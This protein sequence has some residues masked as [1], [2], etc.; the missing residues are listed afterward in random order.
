M[1]R[2]ESLPADLQG[3]LPSFKRYKIA[4]SPNAM[5]YA[6]FFA[7]SPAFRKM[8]ADV[9]ELYICDMRRKFTSESRIKQNSDFESLF[10]NKEELNAFYKCMND[11]SQTCGAE[12][13]SLLEER[14]KVNIIISVKGA[15]LFSNHACDALPHAKTILLLKFSANHYEPL[16][17]LTGKH[18]YET[19]FMTTDSRMTSILQKLAEDTDSLIKNQ[20]GGESIERDYIDNDIT[21]DEVIN[22]EDDCNDND[23]QDNGH[24]ELRVVQVSGGSEPLDS[25]SSP[26]PS[27]SEGDIYSTTPLSLD[28]ALTPSYEDFDKFIIPSSDIEIVKKLKERIRVINKAALQFTRYSKD[29]VTR[30]LYNLLHS[31]H[32]SSASVNELETFR[33]LYM[34]INGTDTP[35]IPFGIDLP[36][37]I[38][39]SVKNGDLRQ[40]FITP[41]VHIVQND[42]NVQAAILSLAT[43]TNSYLQKR[44]DIH[45]ILRPYNDATDE[46][47]SEYAKYLVKKTVEAADEDGTSLKLLGQQ[48]I[49][50]N[51]TRILYN[52][53]YVRIREINVGHKSH[54]A[55]HG[56][57]DIERYVTAAQ[58]LKIGSSALLYFNETHV[59]KDGT[60][61]NKATG[62]VSA[63]NVGMLKIA[64]NDNLQIRKWSDPIT[65]N[66]ITIQL[67]PGSP[68]FVYPINTSNTS[69][70]HKS[71]LDPNNNYHVTI[72]VLSDSH[73]GLSKTLLW[74]I[75]TLNES[76]YVFRKRLEH[77]ANLRDAASALPFDFDE[78]S[79]IHSGALKEHIQ[80][81][82]QEMTNVSHHQ[83]QAV[84]AAAIATT[85]RLYTPRRKSRIPI[86]L[87]FSDL[88]SIKTAYPEL[89]WVTQ[90]HLRDAKFEMDYAL[91]VKYLRDHGHMHTL[92]TYYNWVK[93]RVLDIDTIN[94]KRT[95]LARI[96][97]DYQPE[98]NPFILPLESLNVVKNYASNEDMNSDYG[99][100]LSDWNGAY[101]VCKNNAYIRIIDEWVHV[102]QIVQMP[103][104]ANANGVD[105]LAIHM[106]YLAPTIIGHPTTPDQQEYLKALNDHNVAK[107]QLNALDSC[108]GT[109]SIHTLE[110]HITDLKYAL[111]TPYP[112]VYKSPEPSFIDKYYYDEDEEDIREYVIDAAELFSY[113][114]IQPDKVEP[115][116]FDTASPYV[117]ALAAWYN[118]QLSDADYERARINIET[119]TT[120]VNRNLISRNKPPMNPEAYAG[121]VQ[122]YGQALL[123]IFMQISRIYPTIHNVTADS[124]NTEDLIQFIVNNAPKASVDDPVAKKKIDGA[125]QVLRAYNAIISNRPL[126]AKRVTASMAAGKLS[127][128]PHVATWQGFRPPIIGADEVVVGSKTNVRGYITALYKETTQNS[129]PLFAM[130]NKIPLTRNTCCL[131]PLTHAYS[132][133]DPMTH[134]TDAQAIIK[135]KSSNIFVNCAIPTQNKRAQY[136]EINE[137]SKKHAHTIEKDT[138]SVVEEGLDTMAKSPLFPML[139]ADYDVFAISDETTQLYNALFTN[140]DAPF[141]D[142][143]IIASA[144]AIKTNILQ[145]ENHAVIIEGTFKFIRNDMGR[146]MGSMAY[147]LRIPP[148]GED[149][150][151]N[152]FVI[153]ASIYKRT[154]TDIISTAIMCANT[155]CASH[156]KSHQEKSVALS[157]VALRTLLLLSA[158]VNDIQTENSLD[159]LRASTDVRH[160]RMLMNYLLH[161]WITCVNKSNE[162]NNPDEYKARVSIHREKSK[163]AAIDEMNTMTNDEIRLHR[164]LKQRGIKMPENAAP[165][166][167]APLG[168][169]PPADTGADDWQ[170]YEGENED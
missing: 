7:Q 29:G 57:F 24:D 102:G 52:G 65:N 33:A 147:S 106:M 152:L 80:S 19:T 144:T 96:V 76:I 129:P 5:F 78:I 165:V 38:I 77:I 6:F 11:P 3:L 15:T 169:A 44:A 21:N 67:T 136:P 88:D 42:T 71:L 94:A 141:I 87:I 46:D 48:V 140:T 4:V 9:Q 113:A 1:S 105:F 73:G 103:L 26:S 32:V 131:K 70:F 164:E 93:D 130:V 111:D 64:L 112:P 132:Y 68:A 74:I 107:K 138:T 23:N 41:V 128:T 79:A 134:S 118:V 104:N 158:T 83:Q 126:I 143:S 28:E 56:T 98:S 17:I 10:D 13:W 149:Y 59:D 160:A 151:T 30:E 18:T 137:L 166:S 45:D 127:E 114:E 154:I 34:P 81:V 39:A 121:F 14:F 125:E 95:T 75:P 54:N 72:N 145:S 35:R 97:G 2:L 50:A 31:S 92:Q 60:I 150:I 55:I 148:G 146:I 110:N 49:P 123:V 139:V 156:I 25:Q 117:F 115:T 58:G 51:P 20:V 63:N 69:I 27:S 135:S 124:L 22:E 62:I 142:V 161:I 66:I 36:E 53:D 120:S 122:T 116:T 47:A 86:P 43:S 90:P 100:I 8:S 99:R 109:D 170:N 82:A 40:P 159:S 16:V 89:D 85:K 153:D 84:G 108:K 101:A 163:N 157:Y 168:P 12:A 133:V 37:R 155:V 61:I 91:H 167:L 162:Y 119:A